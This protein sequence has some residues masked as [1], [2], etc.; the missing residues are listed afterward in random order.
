MRIAQAILGDAWGGV[1]PSKLDKGIGGRE[2]SLIRLSR[3]WARLGHQVTNYVPTDKPRRFAEGDGYHEYV[4]FSSVRMGLSTFSYDA[5]VAWECPIVFAD[6]NVREI[7]RVRLVE[8]QCA[9][10]PGGSEQE[11]AARF[12]TGVVALSDWHRDY[13]VHDGLRMDSS[14]LHVLPN[15]VD[16]DLYPK[17]RA[18]EKRRKGPKKFFYSSSPDRG[19]LHL[20]RTWPL[21]RERWPEAE[22]TVAYGVHRLV[23]QVKWMHF[24]QGEMAI[25]I[26]LAMKQEG[27]IDVGTIG[28]RQ[29]SNIQRE[30][31]ALL[32]PCDT[33]QPTETGAI[34]VIEAL[35]AGAPVITTDCDCL[36][37]EFSDV[38]M[39]DRLPFDLLSYFGAI[40]A[41]IDDPELYRQLVLTGR[42]FAETRQWKHVAPRWIEL[43]EREG[44][45]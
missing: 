20:L 23:D 31:T 9:N 13:L 37:E 21:I 30:S 45:R 16:L 36:A 2:G 4:P 19:L 25:D 11:N 3:E 43:F 14:R 7:Q 10:F 39:I 29:L 40:V 18:W 35:A 26:E 32:Y 27:V 41:V 12:A 44:K 34:T 38:A 22:L 33:I 24:K 8:M 17:P 6:H 42:E 15:C 5:V 28:Q 1:D